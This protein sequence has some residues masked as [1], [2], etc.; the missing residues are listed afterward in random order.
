MA[1]IFGV[2]IMAGIAL[3]ILVNLFDPFNAVI[4]IKV[5]FLIAILILLLSLAI[6]VLYAIAV[7]W[8]DGWKYSVARYFGAEADYFKSAFRRGILVAVLMGT[9]L[10]LKHY[11]FFTLY[12]A[13]SAVAIIF[14]LELFYSVH[15]KHVKIV[16]KH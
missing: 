11:S 4:Q 10:G 5:L 1:I 12:F 8:H 7:I 16:S 6:A 13:G 3:G 15:E 9:L 14:I 2:G